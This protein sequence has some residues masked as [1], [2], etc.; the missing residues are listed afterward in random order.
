MILDNALPSFTLAERQ[1]AI[2]ASEDPVVRRAARE[3][4][5]KVG[6]AG[7]DADAAVDAHQQLTAAVADA[8]AVLAPDAAEKVSDF[9]M[10]AALFAVGAPFFIAAPNTD[11]AAWIASM[12]DEALDGLRNS[13]VETARA[14]GR[15]WRRSQ[16]RQ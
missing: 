3:L 6:D 9:A 15:P 12:P 10:Q 1:A 13:M 7:I 5:S 11:M 14:M 2:A 16:N 4:D 8:L